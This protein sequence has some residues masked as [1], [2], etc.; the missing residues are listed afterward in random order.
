MWEIKADYSFSDEANDALTRRLLGIRTNPYKNYAAFQADVLRVTAEAGPIPQDFRNLCSAKRSVDPFDDPYVLLKNCPVD[1]ELP[2][3]DLD[4]PV[5]DKRNRKTTYVAEAFLVLYAELMGQHPIGYIN[6]NDGDVFQDIHPMRS[7]MATQSQKAAKSIFFH[8]DLANHFVRPDWVNIL[9]LRASAQNQI[10]T[11]F[12]RNRDLLAYLDDRVLKGLRE[13]RF[14]TPYDD[15]TLSSSNKKLGP[16]PNH[17]ILGGATGHD[18]RFF[19]NRTVGIDAQAQELVDEVVRALHVLKKRLLI[20]KG[21]FV[22]SANN[23]CIHNK[24]VGRISDEGAVMNRWLMK[25]VNVRSLDMHRVHML[26]SE[27]RIVNG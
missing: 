2:M 11:S 16:A 6:V 8:K 4:N 3:L 14:H 10:H 24:E 18:I 1:P 13:E 25:T 19:E 12:V 21:D 17:P 20:L 26:P 22:G 23:E 7:M 9:G 15:L 27:D 5:V